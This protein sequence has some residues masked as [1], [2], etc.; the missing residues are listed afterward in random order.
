[1][2]GL[3]HVELSVLEYEESIKFY[4]KM[5]G[6]LGYK[7]FWTHNIGYLSTYYTA[8]FPFFHSYIGIQPA[9]SGSQL[10]HED[11]ATGIHHIAL[12]ANSRKTVD[13]FYEKFLLRN[14]IKVTDVPAEYPIYAPSYYAVFFSDP[15]TGIHFELA[16]T[17]TLSSLFGYFKWKRRL[18]TIW[19]EH[20]EWKGSPW[21]EMARKLPSR[22]E[23]VI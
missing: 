16:C 14:N 2:K 3:H 17:S 7:S 5:F 18:E 12:W 8:W 23:Q 19:N 22:D 13:D 1:M 21:K 15:I 20:P 6:W 4:D 10:N 11:H 9:K